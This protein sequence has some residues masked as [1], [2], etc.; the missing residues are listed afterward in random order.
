MTLIKPRVRA[1]PITRRLRRAVPNVGCH[2]TGHVWSCERRAAS[3]LP[4]PRVEFVRHR[5]INAGCENCNDRAEVGERSIG[6]SA[7]V[8]RANDDFVIR[9]IRPISVCVQRIVPRGFNYRNL[10]ASD[11]TVD[12]VPDGKRPCTVAEAQVDHSR[13]LCVRRNPIETTYICAIIRSPISAAGDSD[14]VY[15]GCLCDPAGSRPRTLPT[16]HRSV[17]VQAD[18]TLVNRRTRKTPMLAG[19]RSE[20]AGKRTGQVQLRTYIVREAGLHE[21]SINACS[22][23]EFPKS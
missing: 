3:Q 8:H 15:R 21:H 17:A 14:R 11:E 18:C 10:V 23:L 4:T 22:R 2:D 1:A 16:R 13:F 19:K 6:V 12:G 20:L 9:A 5:Y 7:R